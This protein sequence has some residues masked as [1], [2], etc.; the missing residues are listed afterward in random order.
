MTIGVN[1]KKTA[2]LLIGLMSTLAVAQDRVTKFDTSGDKAV[3]YSELTAACR[4]SRDLFDRADKNSDG[5]LTNAE[6][7]NAK[8]YLFSRCD[9]TRVVKYAADT[10]AVTVQRDK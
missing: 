8:E 7:R 2:I 5:V 4:V 1:M 9:E 6:M 3:D 10:A